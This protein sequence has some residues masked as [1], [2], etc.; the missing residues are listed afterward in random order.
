[1]WSNKRLKVRFFRDT[2]APPLMEWLNTLAPAEDVYSA[3][4]LIHQ[5]RMLPARRRPLWLTAVVDGAPVGLSIVGARGTDLEL[6]RVAL[7]LEE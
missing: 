7:A 1:M 4:Q 3:A 6:I 5:R 2:D